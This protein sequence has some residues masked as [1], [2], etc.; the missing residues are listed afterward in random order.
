METEC[1]LGVL[2]K[3]KKPIYQTNTE[4]GKTPE[5]KRIIANCHYNDEHELIHVFVQPMER[6]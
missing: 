1:D 5:G 4:L 6:P 2:E 3:N